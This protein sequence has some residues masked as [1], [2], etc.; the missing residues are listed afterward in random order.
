MH[1]LERHT[2]AVLSFSLPGLGQ[3]SQKRYLAA[4]AFFSVFTLTST[5]VYSLWAL[6]LTAFLSALETLRWEKPRV[7]G[8]GLRIAYGVVGALGLFWWFGLLSSLFLPARAGVGAELQELKK[9]DYSIL[10]KDPDRPSDLKARCFLLPEVNQALV[11][12]QQRLRVWQATLR[13]EKCYQPGN[14][15]F[16]RG[17]AVVV[18]LAKEGRAR[19]RELLEAME[20]EGFSKKKKGTFLHASWKKAAIQNKLVQ[21]LP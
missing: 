13:V 7:L 5:G 12:V 10:L 8:K 20:A 15:R 6:P 4:V 14:F 2:A 21:D 18:S 17:A 19:P 9:A 16:G 3:L 1:F 11:A